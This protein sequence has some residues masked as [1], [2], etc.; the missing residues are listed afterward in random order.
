M[1]R[2]NLRGGVFLYGIFGKFYLKIYQIY[3]FAREE[4]WS[5]GMGS[6]YVAF[7]ASDKFNSKRQKESLVEVSDSMG[8]L[9]YAYSIDEGINDGAL[10]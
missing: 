5:R 3:S 6:V 8:Q 1:S 7:T 4:S 2:T 9:A 10:S